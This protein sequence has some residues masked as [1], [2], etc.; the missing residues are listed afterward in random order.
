MFVDEFYKIYSSTGFNE[1]DKVVLAALQL[2][3]MAQ[4][5]Y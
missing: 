4:V 2:K 5:W 3:D 1:K